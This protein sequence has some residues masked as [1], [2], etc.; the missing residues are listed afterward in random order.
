ML[1]ASLLSVPSNSS[2]G[3]MR[4]QAVNHAMKRVVLGVVFVAFGGCGGT[5]VLMPPKVDLQAFRKVGLVEFASTPKGDL[6]ELASQDFIES[7]QASQP[8]VPVLDLGR[9]D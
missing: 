8:G 6:E 7:M 3:S 4:R 5:R 9:Q 2:I 1:D